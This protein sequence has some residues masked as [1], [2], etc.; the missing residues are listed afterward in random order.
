MTLVESIDY[1][2]LNETSLSRVNH[3][4]ELSNINDKWLITS[5]TYSSELRDLYDYGTDFAA[6]GS[7]LVRREEVKQTDH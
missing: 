5:D 2:F 1:N 4:I 3:V 7:E 6:L